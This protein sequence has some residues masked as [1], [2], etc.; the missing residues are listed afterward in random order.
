MI[1]KTSYLVSV[2]LSAWTNIQK[3]ICFFHFQSVFSMP[4]R[5][6]W[7]D[8]LVLWCSQASLKQSHVVR[9]C[10]MLF[11]LPFLWAVVC[12]ENS[13]KNHWLSSKF[14]QC[15]P[16]FFLPY[17]EHKKVTYLFTD[18]AHKWLSFLCY[19]SLFRRN[20]QSRHT[21]TPS[22]SL[23]SMLLAWEDLIMCRLG[24]QIFVDRSN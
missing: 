14:F 22:L 6:T 13:A 1:P 21:W 16:L 24:M 15:V 9:F 4:S 23:P 19:S 8:Q 2:L 18:W 3:I 11:N 17:I 7:V 5:S 10:T 20:F 12:R